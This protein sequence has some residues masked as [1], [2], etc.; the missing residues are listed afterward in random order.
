ML[1]YIMLYNVML[2]YISFILLR[3]L[4]RLSNVLLSGLLKRLVRRSLLFRSFFNSSYISL[5]SAFIPLNCMAS[6]FI[7][8]IIPLY[9]LFVVLHVS[10]FVLL[11]LYF[12]FHLS[13]SQLN[14][15]I[16]ISRGLLLLSQWIF[17]NMPC[18]SLILST[19]S[20]SPKFV[21]IVFLNE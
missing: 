4:T 10:L 9:S 19:S 17:F 6:P 13:L 14:S 1:V 2:C 7:L 3:L 21:R 18:F 16:D 8:W 12:W 11:L 15:S 5:H 20:Y